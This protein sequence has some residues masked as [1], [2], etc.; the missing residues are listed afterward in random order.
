MIKSNHCHFTVM[1]L[2]WQQQQQ[3]TGH[4]GAPQLRPCQSLDVFWSNAA[5]AAASHYHSPSHLPLLLKPRGTPW[6]ESAPLFC[7]PVLMDQNVFQII[8]F[9]IKLIYYNWISL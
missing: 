3:Y 9:I 7:I 4:T 5:G 8:L 6:E 2:P 1:M